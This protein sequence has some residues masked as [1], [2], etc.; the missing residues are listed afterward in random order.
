MNDMYL[1]IVQTAFRR[2][3]GF[4]PHNESFPGGM[5]CFIGEESFCRSNGEFNGKVIVVGSPPPTLLV[6]LGIRM[7]ETLPSLRR[8]DDCPAAEGEYSHTESP[9]YLMYHEHEL[10]AGIS[11][12]LRRRPFTR[13]DYA[14]EW[15]NLG[16][17]RIRT[18]DSIWSVCSGCIPDG[19]LELAG[20]FVENASGNNYCGSYMTLFDTPK[21]SVLWCSRPVGP[22]D[23]TEWTVIERFVSDWRA[24]DMPCLPSLCQTPTGCRCLVTM[25]LD[26]DE[27]V[28]SARDVFQWYSKKSIP[29]SLAVKTS[30]NLSDS[31]ISLLNDVRTSGGTLLS[32]SHT[33]NPNWGE[34]L[35]TALKD[36]ELSRSLFAELWPSFP[37]PELAVSPFHTNPPYAVQALES[38]GFTGFVSGIIHNDPEY[39]LGRSGVVPLAEGNIISISQ[40]SMLHG[41]CYSRQ[42]EDVSTHVA[43]FEAQYVARGIFGYLDH[44]FSERYQYD[45]KNSEQRLQAHQQL[46]AAIQNYEGVW[47]WSQ[48]QCFD[49]VQALSA[50]QLR[51]SEGKVLVQSIPDRYDI[52]YRYKG[53]EYTFNKIEP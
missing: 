17:G 9:A 31:D 11:P 41:D 44:P 21:S 10:I 8:Q 7:N 1:S 24:E 27:D 34:N 30:L 46:V 6:G 25:R 48:Q 40:Q 18:D 47:F 51:V 2:S 36:A 15:N 29:F 35:E 19:A 20:M 12:S 5:I 4:I 45:W 53:K 22:V 33:H 32:H 37:L 42:Q 14:N 26:C 23:S 38:A 3:F 49:F 13:F 50:V 28:N 43:A 52:S 39:L 16:F